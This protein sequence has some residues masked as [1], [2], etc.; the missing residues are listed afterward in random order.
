M[1]RRPQDNPRSSSSD[2]VPPELEVLGLRGALCAQPVRLVGATGLTGHRGLR[3]VAIVAIL[4]V[5][6]LVCWLILRQQGDCLLYTEQWP[7]DLVEQRRESASAM[8]WCLRFYSVIYFF[9]VFNLLVKFIFVLQFASR[10]SRGT[11]IVV[12]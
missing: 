10:G 3:L 5:L 1:A 7:L 12:L 4:R 6:A 9:G 8:I 11:G 2:G